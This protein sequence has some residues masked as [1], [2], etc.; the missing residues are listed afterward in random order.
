MHVISFFFGAVG[1]SVIVGLVAHGAGFSGW[2]AIGMGA[3]CFV[4]AQV[5]YLV[6]LAGMA[7]AEA[8][9]RKSEADGSDAAATK[10]NRSVV[11]K[12]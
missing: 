10:P 1:A 7:R 4:L 2:P 9:R 8:R 12:G 5:L 11:Q 3:A 6:W